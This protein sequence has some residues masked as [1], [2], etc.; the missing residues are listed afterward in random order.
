MKSLYTL[1]LLAATT[2][3][4]GTTFAQT[5]TSAATGNDCIPLQDDHQLVRKN[6][7][8]TILLRNGAHHYI[9]HFTSSCSSAAY[10]KKLDFVSRGNEGQLCG[11]RASKLRTDSASCDIEK[12]E[13]I[14]EESFKLRASR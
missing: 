3:I 14:S 6:A 13:P 2:C 10:S 1:C 11:A 8:R 7:D 9:V 5:A 12:I 4:A